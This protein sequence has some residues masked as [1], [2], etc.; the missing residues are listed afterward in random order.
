MTQSGVEN[1]AGNG[2]DNMQPHV[3]LSLPTLHTRSSF[4][5]D[6]QSQY[7]GSPIDGH[8]YGSASL[9]RQGSVAST[10]SNDQYRYLQA[11]PEA[12][13]AP[14]TVSNAYMETVPTYS[15]GSLPSPM[16][17]HYHHQSSHYPSVTYD[18][19]AGFNMAP[20][21]SSLP[22]QT[23]QERRLP[24][25]PA[26]AHAQ[27]QQ[28]PAPV[29]EMQTRP[30]GSF[31]EPR[32]H[33]TGI[34]SRN[35]MPW[36]ID[37]DAFRFRSASTASFAPSSSLA[38]SGA[39]STAAASDPILG[40]Q[41]GLSSATTESSSSATSPTSGP[42]PSDGYGSTSS[43]STGSML[44]PPN[45]AFSSSGQALP[46]MITSDRPSS[47]RSGGPHNPSLYS[48]STESSDR[49]SFGNDYAV[50]HDSVNSNNMVTRNA[51]YP[52][53]IMHP[54]PQHPSNSNGID[55]LHRQSSYDQQQQRAFTAQR[56]SLSNINANY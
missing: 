46:P 9:P 50:A 5:G 3:R 36:S 6:L 41:F 27:Y 35:A 34:H 18:S 45:V 8:P 13:S 55:T 22:L 47:S 42:A 10:Y 29:A 11:V 16:M 39:Q 49:S 56:M 52:T 28:G 12:M 4:P 24:A 15:F 48:F 25:L 23:V 33:I 7:E 38:F 53:T 1:G 37:S 40:Y 14:A 44:P 21:H 26:P 32:V 31:T 43:S 54:Q 19:L 30:L 17:P 2:H 20:L 51:S